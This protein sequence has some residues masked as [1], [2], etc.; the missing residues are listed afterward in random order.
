M[1]KR[2]LSNADSAEPKFV[3]TSVAAALLEAASRGHVQKIEDLLASGANANEAIKD[4]E[5][6]HLPLIAAARNGHLLAAKVLLSAGADVNG[7]A[8]EAFR[9][10]ITP[11]MAAAEC[12]MVDVLK[13]L[14]KAGA[15]IEA[16]DRGLGG[17]GGE[18]ALHYAA[19]GGNAEAIQLLTASGAKINAKAIGGITPL[20]EAVSG[21]N[22]LAAE[23]LLRLGAD[24]NASPRIGAGALY[25]AAFKNDSG[26]VKLLLAYG[27][28]PSPESDKGAFLPLEAA[29]GNG[30]VE[31]VRLLLEAGA[32]VNALTS[33]G[34]TPLCSAGLFGHEK[35]VDV[36]LAAG[37][38]QNFETS[39]GF[40]GLMAG[41]RSGKPY[42]VKRMLAAGAKINALNKDGAS[43]LDMAK[44]GGN[45]S[46][47]ALLEAAGA[48]KGIELRKKPKRS[49]S[50]RAS[51]SEDEVDLPDFT[52]AAN[53]PEFNAIILEIANLCGSKEE[54]LDDIAGGCLFT[55]S[56]N[57]AKSI[58]DG[59]H[60]RLLDRGAYL[61]QLDFD[62]SGEE[63][64]LAL[65]PTGDWADLIRAY[66][67]NGANSG[68]MPEDIITWLKSLSKDH[69]FVLTGFGS[70]WLEGRFLE[71]VKDSRKLARKMYDFC[72]DI[73][74]QGVGSV[75]KLAQGLEKDG[76]FGFW[77][78]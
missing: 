49:A 46:I 55:M 5:G 37:A 16:K 52:E 59:H 4:L 56:T 58:L 73:V 25:F 50:A 53:T 27:A 14:L 12:G 22:R 69:P 65:L 60:S 42:V 57:A 17:D 45:R 64:E 7:T 61:F 72:S 70:D 31:V 38:D 34:S 54:P 51:E 71:P 3:K 48:M 63:D 44:E 24:P 19:R 29:A 66:Q 40:S 62:H 20:L 1:A 47:V 76:K 43:A 74:D 2:N 23:T 13:V 21:K 28:D 68:L 75:R 39:D 6:T 36:L 77:W 32:S 8:N 10:D 35:A 33:T 11:T 67:T 41:V 78:D 15:N 9:V 26:L 30:N 18:T